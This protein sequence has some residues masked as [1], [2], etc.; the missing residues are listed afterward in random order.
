MQTYSGSQGVYRQSNPYGGQ[1]REQYYGNPYA[2]RFSELGRSTTDNYQSDQVRA[3]IVDS[4]NDILA[5][6]IPMDGTFSLFITRDMGRVYAKTWSATGLPQTIEY[7]PKKAEQNPQQ[8]QQN[9]DSN[10]LMAIFERIV[11][12]ENQIS[13]MSQQG[14]MPKY[15][16]KNNQNQAN[17]QS[18]EQKQDLQGGQ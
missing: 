7:E 4:E 14:Q 17:K 11:N 18:K 1:G 13:V 3:R 5:K 8:P 6:E 15:N 12:L 10:I 2:D 9:Q 16:Q